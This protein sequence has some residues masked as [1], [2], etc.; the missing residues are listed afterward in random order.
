[1]PNQKQIESMGQVLIRVPFDLFSFAIG[2]ERDILAPYKVVVTWK[3]EEK[4]PKIDLYGNDPAEPVATNSL[5][6]VDRASLVEPNFISEELLS[7]DGMQVRFELSF[8]ALTDSAGRD[9]VFNNR[10]IAHGEK[11]TIVQ[12]DLRVR[13]DYH[14]RLCGSSDMDTF[15]LLREQ[16]SYRGQD[17]PP[18]WLR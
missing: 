4:N 13:A 16:S 14:L 11:W 15:R 18:D 10:E 9:Q 5:R 8:S 17:L 2:L 7:L 12:A 3:V 1:M 6:Q